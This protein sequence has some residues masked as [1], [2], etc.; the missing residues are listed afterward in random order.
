ME[1]IK[2]FNDYEI[3]AMSNGYK[4]ERWGS[5]YLKRPD[6]EIIWPGNDNNIKVDA[7]YNRSSTG[8]GAW[9]INK[10]VPSSWIVNYKDMKFN[11]KL[12]GFK[13]TGLFPEQA[14]NWD[15]IRNKIKYSNKEVNVLNLFAYT[16]AATVACLSAGASVVHVDSSRGV[17][18]WCKENVKKNGLENSDIHYFVDDVVKFVKRE[19]RRGHK[20]DVIIM[21]PPS[22]G[23]GANK[24][25]WNI[26]TDLYPLINL[27]MELLSDK[28]LFFLINSYTAGLSPMVLDN[29]LKIMFKDYKGK[30]D[31]GEIGLPIKEN[32][33]VLPCGIYG[34]WSDE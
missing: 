33:L 18:D 4:Y 14:Y 29:I 20:Y 2:D 34:R 19:I 26:E 13:H 32:N 16:G 1:T 12:M 24:E 5:V 22:Y 17:V 30:I 31:C 28:P 11:L 10:N 23:R 7:T 15:I 8:G 6:P 21:D 27:C 3:L 9:I 25:I